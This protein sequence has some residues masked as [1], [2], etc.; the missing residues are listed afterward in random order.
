MSYIELIILLTT[1]IFAGLLGGLLGIG[2]SIVC[3]PVMSI[4]LGIPIYIA[5]AAAMISN[6]FVASPAAIRHYKNNAVNILALKTLI[7]S[8]IF[9]IIIGVFISAR[10]NSR[11]L[12]IVFGCFLTYVVFSMI[13][14]LYVKNKKE[15]I[16]QDNQKQNKLHLISVG[17][18][19]GILAGILGIGGGT[20]IVPLLHKTCNFSLK[21]SI[22]TSSGMMI[23]TAA[24]GSIVKLLAIPTSAYSSSDSPLFLY[25]NSVTEAGTL[26]YF[27][28]L[29]EQ[30]SQP[31]LLACALI[32]TA[33]VGSWLGATL[34]NRLPVNI[35]KIIFCLFVSIAAFKMLFG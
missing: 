8:G 32:P 5:Q 13:R 6:V 33:I 22:G 17:S 19:G 30:T 9:A 34:L 16:T 4:G 31:I 15:F 27:L 3:I 26:K 24:I 21:T 11:I 23:M 25:K 29:W 28:L 12:E 1:G 14:S 35:V 7:P 2:G 18:T 20:A 10:I